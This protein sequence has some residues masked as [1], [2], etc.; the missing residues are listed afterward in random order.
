[1]RGYSTAFLPRHRSKVWPNPSLNRRPTT[2]GAVSP[3]RGLCGII[4]DRAYSTY[5]R[6]RR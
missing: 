2:A 6:G 3:V 5:L 1:M 4:A